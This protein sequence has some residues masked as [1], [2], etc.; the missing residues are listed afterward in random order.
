MFLNRLL[1]YYVHI[2]LKEV[3][4]IIIL[5]AVNCILT[6]NVSENKLNDFR[7]NASRGP[8]DC[9]IIRILI[10]SKLRFKTFGSGQCCWLKCRY[11]FSE[12]DSNLYAIFRP[13]EIRNMKANI[14][15]RAF[16]EYLHQ[17]M[18]FQKNKQNRK[19]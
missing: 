5:N 4:I 17:L 2:S 10:Y 12:V 6:K 11:I 8:T 16:L 13:K 18:L 14:Y 9:I 15:S 7:A 1:T 3:V 19:S